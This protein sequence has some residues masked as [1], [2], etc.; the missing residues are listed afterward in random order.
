MGDKLD[1]ESPL[2]EEPEGKRRL[3]ALENELFIPFPNEV[4]ALQ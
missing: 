2:D 1:E 3:L 4:D